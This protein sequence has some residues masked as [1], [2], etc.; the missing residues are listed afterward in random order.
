MRTAL[1]RKYLCG[2]GGTW[3]M[4]SLVVSLATDVASALMHLHLEGI[5][6]GDIKAANIL[7]SSQ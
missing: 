4:L 7:L 1:D 5:V 2:P 3:P 6:H